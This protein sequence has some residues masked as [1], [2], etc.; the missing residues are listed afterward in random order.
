MHIMYIE[1]IHVPIP[2]LQFLTYFSTFPF[3]H[4]CALS[5]P[6]S[7]LIPT[8]SIDCCL[9]VSGYRYWSMG[10]P[11][12]PT[13]PRRADSSSS[14][15]ILCQSLLRQAWDFRN[16]LPCLCWDFGWLTLWQSCGCNLCHYEFMGG[17]FAV[18]FNKYHFAAHTLPS[19][20]YSLSV[21][22]SL[23]IPEL[24]GEVVCCRCPVSSWE[25]HR[26]SFSTSWLAVGLCLHHQLCLKEAS[27]VRVER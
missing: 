10:I 19:G 21:P 22:S 1:P 6:H 24:L 14:A 12:E 9:Y 15:A 18:M 17:S 25:F 27:L 3:P 5:I 8:E 2:F 13:F 11:S 23:M 20:S 16:P 4:P 26:L 7:L